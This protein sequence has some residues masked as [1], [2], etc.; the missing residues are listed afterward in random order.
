MSSNRGRFLASSVLS[1]VVV[2]VAFAQQVADVP[3]RN[4]TVPP[5]RLASGSAGLSPMTDISSGIG[6]V[7]ITPCR[8]ADTRGLGFSGQAGPP[9]INT[10]TR[11]FQI[12]GTVATIPTQCG[13]PVGADAVSFQFTIIQPNVDGNLIAWPAGGTPPTVSVLNWAGGIFALG[14]GTIVPI[15]GGGALS[16]RINAAVGSATGQLVIDVNGY[17]TDLYNPGVSFHAVSATLAPAIWGENTYTVAKNG[18]GVYGTSV[19]GWGVH[20]VTAID[21]GV[22]GY[23]YSTADQNFGV[24]GF[25]ESAVNGSNGV[26]GLA[27]NAAG[28]TYGV[29]G[30]TNSIAQDAAGVFG[31]GRGGLTA[32]NA[33]GFAGAGVRGESRT[34]AGVLGVTEDWEGVRGVVVDSMG[35]PIVSGILG[36]NGNTDYGVYAFGGY[37]GTGAKYFVEPHPSDASKVIRY[38][39]LEGPESGTY[40]R[41]RG[42]FQ[43][44]LARI[45]VPED[46]RLVTDPENLSI[47]VTPIGEMASFAVV[48]ISLEEIVVKSSRNVEFFYIANG[49]RK[50][51][52]HLTPIGPGREY[53][54]ETP[55]AKMPLYLTEGQ[56]EM[57]ISNGTYQPDGTVNM[58]TARRLGWDKEWEKRGR[59]APQP[60]E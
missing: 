13:I 9:A 54:P 33:G 20:G 41:G 38:V 8:I 10:G 35:S 16:V 14:N 7:A 39:S 12:A 50:T 53:M 25:S 55:D 24:F 4:W 57:L 36:L 3:L 49:V 51:H 18:I 42:K 19:N 37:G 17:F 32:G 44:G 5:Y 47:V 60:A 56:K 31:V 34:H 58:E 29:Y 21:I 30:Q 11:T 59:P 28:I 22:F 48:K 26:R 15:S 45:D 43:N 52:K 23:A 27:N 2:S 1:C 46:F 40:F 6:F